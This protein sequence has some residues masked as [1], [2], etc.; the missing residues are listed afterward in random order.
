MLLERNRGNWAEWIR[1]QENTGILDQVLWWNKQSQAGASGRTWTIWEWEWTEDGA[2]GAQ[3]V[4]KIHLDISS[5]WLSHRT[6][7]NSLKV[8]VMRLSIKMRY[9]WRPKSCACFSFPSTSDNP[10]LV[11]CKTVFCC[12]PK[13]S[14]KPENNRGLNNQ[15]LLEL[16]GLSWSVLDL[17]CWAN[18]G[19]NLYPSGCAFHRHCFL[20][21]IEMRCLCLVGIEM[22]VSTVWKRSSL[23]LPRLVRGGQF[24]SCVGVFGS[25]KPPSWFYCYRL[26]FICSL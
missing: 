2:G 7:R 25:L 8:A 4:A 18:S 5:L 13:G 9:N 6:E 23:E 17:E 11:V 24:Y 15:K 16:K 20:F 1:I 14:G 12:L 10:E 21:P 3:G 19:T 26:S 22:N